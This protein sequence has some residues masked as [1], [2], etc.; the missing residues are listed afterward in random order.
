MIGFYIFSALIIV[1]SIFLV[2]TYLLV[3]RIINCGEI[4]IVSGTSST[5]CVHFDFAEYKYRVVKIFKVEN[6]ELINIDISEVYITHN[7]NFDKYLIST[8]TLKRIENMYFT[9]FSNG[10]IYKSN[11]KIDFN[12]I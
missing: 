9:D 6:A 7:S 4:T 1:V 5:I 11:R 12:N 3:L 2:S 8:S 10:I